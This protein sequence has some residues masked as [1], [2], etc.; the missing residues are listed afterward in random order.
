MEVKIKLHPFISILRT[1]LGA[2]MH[3][4]Q[5]LYNQAVATPCYVLL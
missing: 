4:Q 1:E 5:A 2:L 3:E